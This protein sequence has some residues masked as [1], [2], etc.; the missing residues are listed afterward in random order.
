M[1]TSPFRAEV[2]ESRTLFAAGLPDAT[3][4]LTGKQTVGFGNQFDTANA[5][6]PQSDGKVLLAGYTSSNTTG[7]NSF[8]LARLNSDGSLDTSFDSD[9]RVTTD[10]GAGASAQAI[11]AAIVADDKILV[12]GFIAQGSGTDFVF[13]RYNPDGSLDNSFGT[14]GIRVV[15]VGFTSELATSM[16]LSADGSTVYLA[17]S[18]GNGGS[19]SFL[20]ARFDTATG[21]LDASF[22]G[23]DG[24]VTAATPAGWGEIS[25]ITLASD[26]AI[27]AA[28]LQN[29]GTADF[30]VARF[31]PTGELDLN[32]A[33]GG[34]FVTDFAGQGLADEAVGVTL[35]S[36]GKIIAVGFSGNTLPRAGESRFAMLRLNADGSLD[37]TFASGGKYLSAPASARYQSLNSVVVLGDNRVVAVGTSGDPNAPAASPDAIN[38]DFVALR[39]SADG[40]LDTSF[41][42]GGQAAVDLTGYFDQASAVAL[43]SDGRILLAGFS[44]NTSSQ[45]GGSDFGVARLSADS[46]QTGRIATLFAPTPVAQGSPA[47]FTLTLD[48]PATTPLTFTYSTVDGTAL[49]GTD[50]TGVASGILTFNPGE[51]TKTI[52]ITTLANAGNTS[53][54]TFS[55][56]LTP[57]AGVTLTNPTLSATILGA[58]QSAPQPV[59]SINNVSLS[60]PA[61]GQQT[62]ATF[63]LTLDRAST[64]TVTVAYQTAA[65]DAT[66]NTDF[67]PSAGTITFAPGQTTATI[68]VPVLADAVD[69]EAE[70]FVVNLSNPVNAT[71][72]SINQGIATIFNTPANSAALPAITVADITV[73]EP[74][75][76]QTRFASFTVTLSSPATSDVTISF[77]TAD[78]TANANLDYSPLTGQLIIAAG[79]T[80][81]TINI[82]ILQ[83]ALLEGPETFQLL[84]TNATGAILPA[85]TAATAT[86]TNTTPGSSP[87]PTLTVTAPATFVERLSN[88]SL[89]TFTVTLSA[90][91]SDT[92]TVNYATADGTATSTS[93]YTATSGTL[94]FAP[95]ETT[96]TLSIIVNGDVEAEADETFLLNLAGETNATLAAPSS[97]A[98]I[99]N[100]SFTTQAVSGKTKYT[101][102]DA[103]G[104]QVTVSLSGPGT[105]TLYFSTNPG[106]QDLDTVILSDTTSKSKLN[107]TVRRAFTNVSAIHSSTPFALNAKP[108]NLN[109]DLSGPVS[110]VTLN[111]VSGSNIPLNALFTLSNPGKAL[112]LTLGTVSDLSISSSV[113]VSKLT[114]NSWADSNANDTVTLP[115]LSSYTNKGNSPVLISATGGTIKTFSVRGF[116][117]AGGA[118]ATDTLS[119]ISVTGGISNALF[120]AANLLS[121]VTTRGNITDSVLR[122]GNRIGTVSAN[123]LTGSRVLVGVPSSTSAFPTATT[124]FAI[125]SAVLN[126][127][128]LKAFSNSRVIAT[129]INSATLGNVDTGST[130]GV[131]ADSARTLAYTLPN[132]KKTTIKNLSSPEQSQTLGNFSI[133]LV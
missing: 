131:A 79:Q 107:F 54:A 92:V 72:A 17:G 33:T 9:G 6:V 109:G 10:F 105:A 70:S 8:A 23:G 113:A 58:S 41:G 3:F 83:D 96:K 82:P 29:T 87:L 50:F 88:R 19:A 128:T 20:L 73:A 80:T 101:Y 78:G 53:G 110:T 51:T 55:L 94:T 12:G 46:D 5:I 118:T 98:T 32:F 99:T 77:T 85:A 52:T 28:G 14:G 24:I 57:P 69:E 49:A 36:D 18:D 124:D 2:L 4:N 26:G 76:G 108:V 42:N 38:S 106:N 65:G 104:A 95:G 120:D 11:G 91:S 62:F 68:Q 34:F 81:G 13:V 21:N 45:G 39:F 60:E 97:T 47:L 15:D 133:V 25:S 64:E 90:P 122:A 22:G 103:A 132:A 84:L 31:T 30:A 27:I 48:Q 75:A 44:G 114:V 66:A 115:S 63:V 61:Q 43:Q 40:A 67:I 93:D 37:N 89:L 102:T 86:I 126:K 71:L 117:T 111:S 129:N 127:L 125:P 123:T 100:A 16:R 35:Q 112:S 74:D 130:S 116:V 59:I 121:K 119:N 7:L 56:T 1:N